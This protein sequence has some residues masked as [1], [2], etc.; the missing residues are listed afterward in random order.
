MALQL[1]DSV[2]ILYPEFDF[3]FLY[4]H[5]QG[6]ARKRDGALDAKKCQRSLDVL[7]QSYGLGLSH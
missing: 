1:V 3:L 6:H 2:K 7:S 5:S 4:D